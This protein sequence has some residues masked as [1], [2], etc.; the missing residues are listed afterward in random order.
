MWAEQ[1]V[2]CC[3]YDG[4][5]KL[6]STLS[7]VAATLLVKVHRCEF[8][9]PLDACWINVSL[10]LPS[11]DYKWTG[12][13]RSP[14]SILYMLIW[15][16]C[17]LKPV[18]P[19][20]LTARKCPMRCDVG[21]SLSTLSLAGFS[22]HSADVYE[23]FSDLP[24]ETFAPPSVSDGLRRTTWID[25]ILWPWAG[26]LNHWDLS[27]FLIWSDDRC[28]GVRKAAWRRLWQQTALHKIWQVA[29]SDV[30]SATSLKVKNLFGSWSWKEVSWPELIPAEA[31]ISCY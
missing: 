22:C 5:T 23:L 10:P 11:I 3:P 4:S 15:Y 6:T 18:V 16:D 17:A 21:R 24:K 30:T 29:S 26:G 27:W 19:N 14:L 7:V 13:E 9:S 20:L 31:N 25:F 2:V 8:P 1:D 12:G 28:C